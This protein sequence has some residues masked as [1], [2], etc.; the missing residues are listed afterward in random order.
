[1]IRTPSAGV[2]GADRLTRASV[3]DVVGAVLVAERPAAPGGAAVA[4]AA[5]PPAAAA[6]AAGAGVGGA[7]G[8]RGGHIRSAAARPEGR[9]EGVR[10]AAHGRPL[11]PARRLARRRPPHRPCRTH[12]QERRI[13]RQSAIQQLVFFRI[14]YY[15][16]PHL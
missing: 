16:D 13:R 3:S 11:R 2:L 8:P 10:L 4:A 14:L 5:R 12:P 7:G 1:M 9:P 6:P 15:F